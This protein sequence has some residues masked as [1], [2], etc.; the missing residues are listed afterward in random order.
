M[1]VINE[2]ARGRN[3]DS[4]NDAYQELKDEAG[5]EACSVGLIIG[6]RKVL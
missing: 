5:E 3:E 6:V 1:D 4:Y 2:R